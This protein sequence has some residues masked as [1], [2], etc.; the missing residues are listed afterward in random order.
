MRT[1]EP[2]TAVYYAVKLV[3]SNWKFFLPQHEGERLCE[4]LEARS[5]LD[6]ADQK[7]FF[8]GED[9]A[10][11]DTIIQFSHIETVWYSSPETRQWEREWNTKANE[12][13]D[14]NTNE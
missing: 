11:A 4:F 3:C 6:A 2:A 10:G 12:E 13:R 8:R 14:W 7:A 9:L 5:T 1:A